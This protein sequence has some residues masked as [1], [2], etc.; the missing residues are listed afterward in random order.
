MDLNV[1]ENP[2][3]LVGSSF[4]ILLIL[5]SARNSR[6][7][8]YRIWLFLFPVIIA[9][10]GFGLDYLVKTDYEK[11]DHVIDVGIEA[12]S[13]KNI[14]LL[15]SIISPT[16]R[17]S[18]NLSKTRIINYC[19]SILSKASV[20]KAER[21][22][23]T[24]TLSSDE[25]LAKLQIKI[26]METDSVYAMAGNLALINI[27]VHFVKTQNAKW[28]INNTEIMKINQQKVRYKSIKW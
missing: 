28:L 14:N 17:D 11:I 15:E 16:Y 25:A 19:Q 10:A 5:A 23:E 4:V 20:K 13:T 21:L 12:V 8:K 1:F 27:D 3:I 7:E 22:H 6:P 24:I 9:G 26:H 2:W 18:V